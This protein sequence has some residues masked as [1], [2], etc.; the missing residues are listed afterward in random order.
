MPNR[1]PGPHI[2]DTRAHLHPDDGRVAAAPGLWSRARPRHPRAPTMGYIFIA[3]LAEM[4][5]MGVSAPMLP[6]LIKQLVGGDLQRAVLLVGWV[7]ALPAV[8][9]FLVL[10]MIGRLSDQFG[11]KPVLLLS[12]AGQAFDYLVMALAPV[13]G[14]LFLGRAV[15]GVS[16]S[17]FATAIAYVSDITAPEERAKRFGML[18]AAF[19]IGL[20]IGPAIG[21]LLAQMDTRLPFWFASGICGASMVYTLLWVPE[22]LPR[23]RRVKAVARL[24]NPLNTLAIYWT[25]PHLA[26]LALILTL[27]YLA[28]QVLYSAAIPYLDYRYAWSPAMLGLSA[29]ALGVAAALVQ[30]FAVS[31]ILTRLG[32]RAALC[33]GLAAGGLGMV[34]FGAAPTGL[35]FMAAVPIYALAGI[36]EPIVSSVMSSRTS[37]ADQGA[38]QGANAAVHAMICAAGPVLFTDIFARTL[39]SWSSWAPT[40]LTFF[41]AAAFLLLALGATLLLP[42]QEDRS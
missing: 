5:A 41:T 30:L 39:G 11:R 22:S 38:L 10:P 19:S 18:G 34:L 2:P 6:G 24:T 12:M 36:Q 20:I 27:L 29:T 35:V 33:V 32:W 17:G 3:I 26:R 16:S 23:A 14:W 13:V 31:P 15:A 8:L 40:G 42:K 1:T 28:R 37:P 9:Q 7:A 4:L 25:V 21:G